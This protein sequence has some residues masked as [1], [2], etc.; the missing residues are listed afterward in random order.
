MGYCSYCT[1]LIHGAEENSS[2]F[3]AA[4]EVN[5]SAP[6]AVPYVTLGF[7]IRS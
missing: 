6:T 5:S 3:V 4:P 7:E 1:T 2:L